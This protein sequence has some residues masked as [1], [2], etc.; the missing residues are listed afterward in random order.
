[1][2]NSNQIINFNKNADKVLGVLTA[3]Y[4]TTL[5]ANVTI[6]YRYISIFHIDLAGGIFIFPLSFIIADVISEVYDSSY[7]KSLILYGFICQLL[8]SLYVYFIIRM[9]YPI[10]WNKQSIYLEVMN[11]YLRFTLASAMAIILGSWLNIYFLS[12]WSEL[13][14]GRYFILRSMGAALIGELFVTVFSMLLANFGKMEATQLIYMMVCCFSVKTLVSLIAVLPAAIFV[15]LL[16]GEQLNFDRSQNHNWFQNLIIKLNNFSKPKFRLDK[17][18]TETKKANIYCRGSRVTIEQD[19]AEIVLNPKIIQN[20]EP[21][22]SSYIGYYYGLLYDVTNKEISFTQNTKKEKQFYLNY[23]HDKYVL[24]S[25]H[26]DG[27]VS[28]SKNESIADD[29]LIK[30]PIEIYRNHLLLSQFESSHACY[31]GLLVGMDQRKSGKAK[32]THSPLKLITSNT[33]IT[34]PS[35]C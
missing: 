29:T 24:L 25:I 23:L 12:R 1:M 32:A 33:K 20:M 5:L 15:C 26:R 35:L 3:L 34:E 22:H 28:Y 7:A 19:I 27:K 6:G 31:I 17:I 4:I 30:K 16:N 2:D 10:F 11:P 8:F 9:P 18:V 14:H 21:I 13:L